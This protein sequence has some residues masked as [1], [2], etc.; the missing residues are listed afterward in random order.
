MAIIISIIILCIVRLQLPYYELSN[1]SNF[2][3]FNKEISDFENSV[4][5]DTTNNYNDYVLDYSK[6]SRVVSMQSTLYNF[7]PN[8][9]DSVGFLKLGLSPKQTKI[10]CNFRRKGGK[11]YNKESFKRIYGINEKLYNKLEP[12]IVIEKEIITPKF[13]QNK[14]T[15]RRIT[16]FEKFKTPENI[17]IEINEADTTLLK[18]LPGIGST[19]AKR[20]IAY[21]EKLGGYIHKKQLFEVIGVDTIIYKLLEKSLVIDTNQIIKINVNSVTYYQL[22]RFPYIKQYQAKALL[23]YRDKHGAFTKPADIKNCL[24]IDDETY[25]KLRPYIIAK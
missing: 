24:V 13:T 9:L 12:Y 19:F 25:K 6:D 20:L 18:K 1:P 7:N 16:K 8:T 23:N 10:V 2:T 22:I 5:A 3:A 11:F 21:R 4:I 15:A 14:D 17:I